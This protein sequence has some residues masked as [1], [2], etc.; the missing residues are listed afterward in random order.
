MHVHDQ[1]E[2]KRDDDQEEASSQM[3]IVDEIK[4]ARQD[5]TNNS[6]SEIP[7][8]IH[9]ANKSEPQNASR[10][11]TINQESTIHAQ[12]DSSQL[13][14]PIG[15]LII[16]QHSEQLSKYSVSQQEL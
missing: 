11:I 1:Q 10:R 12:E 5:N 15:A 8:F 14:G 6:S 9:Q 2:D 7:G 3:I 13:Q 4:Y 16:N